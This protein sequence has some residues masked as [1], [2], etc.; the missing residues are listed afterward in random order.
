MHIEFLVEESSMEATLQQIVPKML[1]DRATFAIHV[2]GGKVSLI[3]KLPN[4]LRGYS[5]WLP[6]NWRIVVL[7][8]RD[9][10]DCHELKQKLESMCR[11]TGLISKSSANSLDQ[12][13][14]INRIVAEELEAWFFGDIPALRLAY[15]KI[16][17][18]SRKQKYRNPD[19]I[20]GGTWETLE[21]LLQRAGYYRG[22]LPKIEVAQSISKHMEPTRNQSKSFQVFQNALVDLLH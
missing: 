3:N 12:V 14:V 18:I 7:V 17:D 4:R 1:K 16:P 6:T 5:R 8:D 2:M 10:D 22:G 19:E 13:Q 11:D 15:P 9:D 21:R 20:T